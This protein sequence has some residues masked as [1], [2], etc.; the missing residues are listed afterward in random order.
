MSLFSIFSKAP[1][2]PTSVAEALAGSAAPARSKSRRPE[3]RADREQSEQLIPEKKR[4]RRRL[5]GA[6]VIVLAVVVGLPMVLDSEPKP[7]NKNISIQ[8]PSRDATPALNAARD[9]RVPEEAAIQPAPRATESA[10]VVATPVP[11]LAPVAAPVVSPAPAARPMEPDSRHVAERSTDKSADN[12]VSDKQVEKKTLR[13]PAEKPAEQQTAKKEVPIKPK[14]AVGSTASDNARAMAILD[15][16]DPGGS[17]GLSAKAHE[18]A[19]A[20][21]AKSEKVVIQVGAFATQEKVSELQSKLSSAGIKS[22][23]QK[24]ATSTGDKTRVRIGPFADREAAA[25]VKA[26][27]EKLGLTP[28]L[29]PQ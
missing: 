16:V 14:V 12:K 18:P 7:L 26:Q 10:P 20:T 29:I 15:G 24:V 6:V 11:A 9:Q 3:N 5:I 23:T 22:F 25:R 19:N 13:Q 4:A 8:I 28:T 1:P 17:P 21:P 27:C 2:E